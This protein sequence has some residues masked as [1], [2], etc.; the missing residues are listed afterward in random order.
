MAI[1]RIG[2]PLSPA[3]VVVLSSWLAACGGGG[4]SSGPAGPG[5]SPTPSPRGLRTSGNRILQP[6]GQVWMGRGVNMP[7]TRSCDNC[8]FE[9]SNAGEVRRRVDEAVDNWGAN[10]L[11]LNLESYARGDG[12]VH[13]LGVL[14][15]AAYL[16]DIRAIVAHVGTKPNVFVMVSVWNDPTF[17]SFGAPTGETIRIWQRLAE[18]FRTDAHVLFGVANEPEFNF[19][20]ARDAQVW[21]AMNDVVAAIRAVED[22]AQGSVRHLV[23]VQGT[24]EWARILDYY[25]QNPIQAGGGQNVVYETHVYDPASR[26]DELFV[27]PARTLPVIIGEFGPINEPDAPVMTISD[28]QQLMARADTVQV[29]YLAWTFHHFCPPNL[30]APAAAGCGVGM[31]LV[32]TNWGTVVRDHLRQFRR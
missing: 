5:P 15:D 21:R 2:R 30:L 29:P 17:D 20:G 4:S 11:R 3:A 14:D 10:F 18:T 25:V 12:R 28:A 6:D 31:P 24:R 22:A 26:F 19:D 16:N 1:G 8:T 7:D 9:A 23:A 27:N 13:F 32:P